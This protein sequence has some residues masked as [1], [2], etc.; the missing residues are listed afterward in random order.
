MTLVVVCWFV[1][2]GACPGRSGAQTR[3][4][5]R[6]RRAGEGDGVFQATGTSGLPPCLVWS[7]YVHMR[8]CELDGRAKKRIWTASVERYHQSRLRVGRIPRRCC[9]SHCPRARKYSVAS[10]RPTVCRYGR[11]ALCRVECRLTPC[12]APSDCASI[13]PFLT[14]VFYSDGLRLRPSHPRGPEQQRAG[15]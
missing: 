11:G 6:E 2:P 1:L 8:R 13:V 12:T 14:S 5:R 4:R 9:A 10:N 15:L 3:C 7:A